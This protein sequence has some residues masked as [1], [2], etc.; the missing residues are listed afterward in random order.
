ML[1]IVGLGAGGLDLLTLQA[2]RRLK[3]VEEVYLRTAVHPAA[4]ELQAEGIGY[5]SFDELYETAEQ[6]VDIYEE[7]AAKVINSTNQEDDVVY[8]VPGH[9][10]VAEE[11]VHKITGQLSADEYEVIAAPSFL[12]A[13]FTCLEIDPIGGV[14]VIDGL[15]F[16][17]RDLDPKAG[18]VIT[19]V[20][21]QSVASEVKLNLMEVYP[22]QFKIKVIRGAGLAEEKLATIPLYKLDRLDWIDHL[23]SV[24]LPPQ[25]A[26]PTQFTRLVE[27]MEIL[28]GEAG[29]PWDR[30]QDYASLKKHLLEETYEVIERIDNQDYFGLEEELGDLLLQV[31]FQSQIAAEEGKFTAKDVITSIVNKLIRRHPHVF[32]D[33]EVADAEEVLVNWAA[34]KKEE[35]NRDQKS[36]SLLDEVPLQLPALEQAQQLQKKA[37]KVGFDWAEEAGVRAKIAEEVEEFREAAANNSLAEVQKEFGDLLFS[38]VNLSR[39]LDINAETSLLATINKF[40]TRFHYMEEQALAAGQELSQLSL[41]E[42]EELWQAAKEN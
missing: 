20:Y 30:E 31:V 3:T 17:A 34:I 36:T 4:E 41:A 24:Y 35:K 37:A 2:Y 32:G 12:D 14:K 28:R 19:Q 10:M 15:D 23:T 13:I 9:P 39:F 6:F 42:L 1:S 16:T 7:I 21:N 25:P 22:D 38:L 40:R 11:T 29:C 33:Q 27:I 5:I 18:T 26:N 8:A